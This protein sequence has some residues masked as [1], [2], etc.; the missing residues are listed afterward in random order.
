MSQ[1]IYNCT[2]PHTSY[3][4]CSLLMVVAFKVVNRKQKPWDI[5]LDKLG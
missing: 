1:Y 5:E 4:A 3:A 2:C